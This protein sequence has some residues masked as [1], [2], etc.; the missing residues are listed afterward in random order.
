M[1]AGAAL[2][3]LRRYGVAVARAPAFFVNNDEA[4]ETLFALQRRRH[5]RAP[6]RSTCAPSHRRRS[7]PARWASRCFRR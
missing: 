2:G 3:Y 7:A 4:Y 5:A 1:L 6:P